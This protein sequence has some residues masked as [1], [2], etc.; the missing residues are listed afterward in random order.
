MNEKAK[1]TKV[2]SNLIWRFSQVFG[3]NMVS[4]VVSIV[5]GRILDPEVYGTVA[6][7]TVITTI[8]QVFV[9]SGLG[10]ALV[11]KKDADDLDF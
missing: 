2:F 9:D 5:L 4:L 6:I 10:N 11:Q 7:V 8:L 3:S 1:D